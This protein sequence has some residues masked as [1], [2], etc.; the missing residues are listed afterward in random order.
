[1]DSLP[2]GPPG[3][4]LINI[5]IPERKIHRGSDVFF[6]LGPQRKEGERQMSTGRVN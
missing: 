6:S 1:M 3:I 2:R 5:V 4:L